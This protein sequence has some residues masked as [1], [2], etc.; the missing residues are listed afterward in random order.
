MKKIRLIVAD[1]NELYLESLAAY[2]RSSSDSTRFIVSLFSKTETLEMYINQGENI[3][4]LLI[5]PQ[6]F[7]DSLKVSQ[8]TIII[9]LDDD[10]VAK[11]TNNYASVYR[12]QRLNQ[13]V[14]DVLAIY[15]QENEL[16]GMLLARS[17]QTSVLSVFSPVGGSGKTTVAIN[18][19]KQ[20]ALNGSKVFYLN[21]ELLNTTKLYF[22]SL[23]D[24]P[25]LQIL[26]YIKAESNQLLSKIES[27]K[28]YDPYSMVDY[29]DIEISAEEMLELNESD[30]NKLIN[31]V[32]QTGS[33]DYIVVDLDSSLHKRNIA[34]LKECDQ[35]IWNISND[36]QSLLKSKS[37]LVEEEK[38]F[39]EENILQDK[40]LVIMNK[41]NGTMV[42]STED[43]DLSIDGFLPLIPSWSTLQSGSEIL[44][45]DLFNQEI[46]A[47]IRGK[48]VREQEGVTSID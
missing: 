13:L 21:L 4:I 1:N 32:V 30:V 25:S 6:M 39:G 41:Y 47:I 27:L 28:K 33:Y 19:C 8:S 11:P 35:V 14:S 10:K 20:L 18:L 34:A 15:Y 22:S 7:T 9:F 12:Y 29:F 45:N 40:L 2:L 48:I 38:L 42:G 31:S 23:E 17:K 44:G 37:L 24:N 46:Q 26:Y 43:F 36:I 3:D 16:A 5:N